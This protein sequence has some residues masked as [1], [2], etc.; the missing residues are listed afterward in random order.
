MPEASSPRRQILLIEDD[1]A[2]VALMAK[3]LLAHGYGVSV[4]RD[5]LE[6]LKALDQTPPDL[7]VVDVM[8][9]RLDGMTLVRAIKKHRTTRHI[10]VIFLTA[11]SDSRS[12]VEG[13]NLGAKFYITK[14]FSL[15]DLLAKVQRALK[16]SP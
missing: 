8:M 12:M 7:I 5:G 16:P 10:P 2:L 13:I 11:K 6:G 9:P 1:A 15:D 3:T 14:P 4:A